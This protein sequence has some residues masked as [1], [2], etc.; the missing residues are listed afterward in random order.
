MTVSTQVLAFLWQDESEW[1][2]Q[3]RCEATQR[4]GHPGP[5]KS[6]SSDPKVRQKEPRV[7]ATQSQIRHPNKPRETWFH[8]VPPRSPAGVQTTFTTYT[9][10]FLRASPSVLPK[11]CVLHTRIPPEVPW[12][13]GYNYPW[14]PSSILWSHRASI[15]TLDHT[16]S[17]SAQS[18]APGSIVVSSW[19]HA[20]SGLSGY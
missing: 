1:C 17:V 3:I 12:P 10:L 11:S 18:S 2:H 4:P 5:Q 6:F 9:E 14:F 13:E 8:G 16:L 20:K 15:F 7:C 19:C